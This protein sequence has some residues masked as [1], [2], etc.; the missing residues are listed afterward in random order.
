[1]NIIDVKIQETEEFLSILKSH[2]AK[3]ENDLYIWK[4]IKR[5]Y[6]GSFKDTLN[7]P[8]YSTA[9]QQVIHILTNILRRASK[10]KEIENV[11]EEYHKENPENT[12]QIH[13]VVRRLKTEGLITAIKYNRQ[14]KTTFWISHNLRTVQQADIIL[15][16]EQGRILE[17][18][19]HLEL[20]Q[21]NGRYARLYHLQSEAAER[22][23]ACSLN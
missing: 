21:Q 19:T 16:I 12:V 13:Q 4:S 9:E 2:L 23:Q 3:C 6:S 10:M 14:N 7:Y 18:G 1:M 11:Y 17:R 15:Y 22:P 5:N 8:T 20:M